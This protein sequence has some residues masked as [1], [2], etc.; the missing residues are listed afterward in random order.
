MLDVPAEQRTPFAYKWHCLLSRHY[1][2]LH[3]LLA[4]FEQELGAGY[5]QRD[6]AV[7]PQSPGQSAGYAKILYPASFPGKFKCHVIR[8]RQGDSGTK[9]G[10]NVPGDFFRSV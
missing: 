6:S 5:C 7:R 2:V 1:A 8:K 10:I 4:F 9:Q 3:E